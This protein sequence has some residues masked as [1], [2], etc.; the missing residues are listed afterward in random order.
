MQCLSIELILFLYLLIRIAGKKPKKGHVSVSSVG[1]HGTRIGQN[2]IL[3]SICTQ[4]H[5]CF[6]GAVYSIIN[7]KII[8]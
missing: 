6:I 8:I 3:A 4:A 7:L 1:G 5:Y 2:T